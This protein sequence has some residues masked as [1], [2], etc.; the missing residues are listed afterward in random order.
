MDPRSPVLVIFLATAPFF[1]LFFCPKSYRH[2]SA[3]TA[4]QCIIFIHFAQKKSEFSP[5][6][7]TKTTL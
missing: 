3:K 5:P 2:L 7:P 6:N 1:L 4:P